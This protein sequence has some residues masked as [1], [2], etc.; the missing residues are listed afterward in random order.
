MDTSGKAPWSPTEKL[1]CEDR[2]TDRGKR[3]GHPTTISFAAGAGGVFQ[4]AMAPCLLDASRETLFR[5]RPR[6]CFAVLKNGLC[7]AAPGRVKVGRVARLP[8]GRGM[9]EVATPARVCPTIRRFRISGTSCQQRELRL[10][11]HIRVSW[12]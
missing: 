2:Q 3:G 5:I 9:I 1:R 8:P 7:G 4:S 10:V 6:R 12:P 11:H